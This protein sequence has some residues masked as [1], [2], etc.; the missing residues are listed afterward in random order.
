M[1]CC[2]RSRAA[3]D[4]LH[5][6]D[7]YDEFEGSCYKFVNKSYSWNQARY[8]CQQD[9]ADLASITS[10]S[11][12]DFVYS[13]IAECEY[14]ALTVCAFLYVCVRLRSFCFSGFQ[15]VDRAALNGVHHV[16]RVDQLRSC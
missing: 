13:N 15:C 12:N 2:F 4:T 16:L 7:D 3:P 5:C 14:T 11:E 9:N 6:A 10:Q 8:M 1:V